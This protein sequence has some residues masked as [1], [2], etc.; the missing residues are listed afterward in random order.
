MANDDKSPEMIAHSPDAPSYEPPQLIVIGDA[1]RVILGV[2][3]SGDDMFG[4]SPPEFEFEADGDEPSG[5]VP[6][7]R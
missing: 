1:M 4:F 3:G 7:V 5:Q 2:S 6:T